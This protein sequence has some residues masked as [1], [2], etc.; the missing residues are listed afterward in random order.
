[1][2]S[3][4]ARSVAVVEDLLRDSSLGAYVVLV[5]HADVVKLILAYY[6]GTPVDRARFT[7][8]ANASISALLFADDP[9]PH[10][11]AVNWTP[12]PGWLAPFPVPRPPRA[13][14][15]PPGGGAEPVRPVPSTSSQPEAAAAA[16]APPE[17]R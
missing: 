9:Q 7:S 13:E 1:F 10:L 3:V 11:L 14:Q 15:Q 4:Q 5:A 17:Q 2:P 16:S 8:I 12:F 6:S